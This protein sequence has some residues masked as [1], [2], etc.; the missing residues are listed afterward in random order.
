MRKPVE[1][2]TVFFTFNGR[3]SMENK[4]TRLVING[5]K[6]VV[7]KTVLGLARFTFVKVTDVKVFGAGD[8]GNVETT[9]EMAN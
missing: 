1:T 7:E 8:D 5:A 9:V 4:I 3:R 6:N 2:K